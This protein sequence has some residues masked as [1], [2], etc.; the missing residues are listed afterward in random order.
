MRKQRNF[1]AGDIYHLTT[2]SNNRSWTFAYNWSKRLIV[3]ALYDMKARYDFKLYNFCV[4]SNHIHL[5][6]SPAAPD[7][8]PKMTQWFKTQTAKQWNFI[9]GASGHLW[10]SRYF[11]KEVRGDEEFWRVMDYIDRNPL[12]AGLARTVGEWKE[13]GAYHIL[14]NEK[15]LVDYTTAAQ[16]MYT[17]KTILLLPAPS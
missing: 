11:A 4:M 13:S 17:R 12:K 3:K 1:I 2:R 6:V 14:R 16:D 7:T 5:L 8:I 10:G 9:H 15:G